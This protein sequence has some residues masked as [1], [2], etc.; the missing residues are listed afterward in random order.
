MNI[1]YTTF[2]RFPN[3]KA[4][5]KQ[6][7]DVC[8]TLVK[9]QSVTLIIPN[10]RV[11]GTAEDFGLDTRVRIVRIPG[12]DFARVPWLGL[13]GWVISITLFALGA[14]LYTLGQTLRGRRPVVFTREYFCAVLPAL[15]FIQTAWESHRGQWNAAIWL[16][17]KLKVQ[18]FVISNGLREFYQAHQVQPEQLT[19]VPDGVDLWRYEQLPTRSMARQQLGLD[20]TRHLVV[21]TGH[22]R[23][24][25]G[26]DILAAA[27]KQLPDTVE[28]MFV[29]GTDDDIA[30]FRHKY[31]TTSNITIA[32]RHDDAVALYQRAADMV[33]IPNTATTAISAKY[34]S[35]LKLFEYMASGSPIVASDVPSIRE[36]LSDEAAFF[37]TPDNADA[38]AEVINKVIHNPES[39]ITRAEQ[40][41]K[42]VQQYSWDVRAELVV[43][44]LQQRHGQ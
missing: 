21:Y 43:A 20:S 9:L 6:I 24:W 14:F 32:G 33:V 34:T 18:F 26:V 1:F 11:D 31:E 4:H 10:R 30:A 17:W 23:A 16:C 25:K 40:A 7:R 8:N 38:L 22:L 5:A 15:F 39:A 36:V 27:A 37:V 28:V 41:Q 42:L 12:L 35:P 3:E 44:V 19:L 2:T 13:T 29:G